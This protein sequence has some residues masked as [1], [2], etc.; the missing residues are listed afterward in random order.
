M[1]IIIAAVLFVLPVAVLAAEAPKSP[2]TLLLEKPKSLTVA[3]VLQIN[4]GLAAMNCGNRVLKDAGN[5]K[6]SCV[7]YDWSVGMSRRI[8]TYE[9]Q[10]EEVVRIYYKKKSQKLAALPRD[11]EGKISAAIDANFALVDNAMLDEE[12]GLILEPFTYVEL[13]PMKLPPSTLNDI[14][15]IT[16]TDDEKVKP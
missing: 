12:S 5:E 4:R 6:M 16:K 11:G 3:Q 10:T 15:P 2:P 7:P 8:S 14:W 13:D 1:K 9:H